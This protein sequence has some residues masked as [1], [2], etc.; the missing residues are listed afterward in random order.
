MQAAVDNLI[1]ET[2]TQLK[3]KVIAEVIKDGKTYFIAAKPQGLEV[4]HQR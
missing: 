1:C 2:T 4:H 3:P